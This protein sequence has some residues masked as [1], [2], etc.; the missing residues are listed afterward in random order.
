MRL[1]VVPRLNTSTLNNL[2]GSL[3]QRGGRSFLCGLQ[4]FSFDHPIDDE[5]QVYLTCLL[6]TPALQDIRFHLKHTAMHNVGTAT[7]MLCDRL[8]CTQGGLT[9]LDLDIG[10][11]KANRRAL[12]L[13]LQRQSSLRFIR[14]GQG[15]QD[16]AVFVALSRLPALERLDLVG[17]SLRGLSAGDNE[18]VENIKEA[19]FN[20]FSRLTWM[21]GEPEVTS[22]VWAAT[23]HF[24]LA[25]GLRVNVGRDPLDAR[26]IQ[27]GLSVLTPAFAEAIT[28]VRLGV[29]AFSGGTRYAHPPIIPNLLGCSNLQE[30]YVDGLI[31]NQELETLTRR[32][33]PLLESLTWKSTVP[34]TRSHNQGISW[35]TLGSISK[36]CLSVQRLD[37]PVETS[38]DM[39]AASAFHRMTHIK[40]MAV[41]QW[42]PTPR[43][44]SKPIL[45][46]SSLAPTAKNRGSVKSWV[47]L[48][49]QSSDFSNPTRINCWTDIINSVDKVL[50][51]RQ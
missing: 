23:E 48:L 18:D 10:P 33:W 34:R 43:D 11:G 37:I 39:P 22:M 35:A 25:A 31:Q 50:V 42:L 1:T 44:T 16:E 20:G 4:K 8:Q 27:N 41:R 40:R 5:R 24:P 29:G 46:L 3:A 13:A 17:W 47:V 38:S 6:V 36:Q 7:R 51:Q 14:L 26:L 12:L 45:V 9:S 28:S 30:L 15:C 2:Q 32:C 49:V 21:S 19:S